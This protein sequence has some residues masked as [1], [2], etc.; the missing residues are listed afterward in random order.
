MSA[1]KTCGATPGF[2]ECRPLTHA[3]AAER[4]R[5]IE[6]M[7]MRAVELSA[8]GWAVAAHEM[9]MLANDLEQQA[10]TGTGAL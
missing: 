7:R 10:R 8:K 3:A 5:I 4:G 9:D 1:C 2:E 6:A